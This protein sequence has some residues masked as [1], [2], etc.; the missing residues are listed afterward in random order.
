MHESAVQQA[1]TAAARKAGQE[2][3]GHADASTTMV[4]TRVLN[5]GGLAV[6]SP[7]DRWSALLRAGLSQSNMSG[8]PACGHV[9]L[10]R[11]RNDPR[12]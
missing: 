11:F 2:L 12:M 10:R 4:Y 1:V 6:K 3:L 9:Y 8:S 5:R 7:L